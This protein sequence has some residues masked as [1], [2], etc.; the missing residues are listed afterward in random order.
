MQAHIQCTRG[1]LT[2]VDKQAHNAHRQMGTHLHTHTHTEEK[3]ERRRTREIECMTEEKREGEKG[4]RPCTEEQ[5]HCNVMS[6]SYTFR[7]VVS[8][9]ARNI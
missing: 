2:K 7:L 4:M 6:H 3:K 8:G 1:G 9:I 5:I